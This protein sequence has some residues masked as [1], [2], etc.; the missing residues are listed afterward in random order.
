MHC[1]KR[2][3]LS[4]EA[5][6][7]WLSVLSRSAYIDLDESAR[8]DADH[9]L[10]LHMQSASTLVIAGLAHNGDQH[11]GDGERKVMVGAGGFIEVDIGGSAKYAQPG[12]EGLTAQQQA[13]DAMHIQAKNLGV[14][15]L[16]NA[17][18]GESGDAMNVRL[19]ARTATLVQVASA[20]AAEP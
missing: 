4:R 18:A 9:K 2:L 12:A 10:N 17:G 19:I 7:A 5:F 15:I 20:G 16:G 6:S 3:L 1:I 14:D 11:D 8:L 13:L